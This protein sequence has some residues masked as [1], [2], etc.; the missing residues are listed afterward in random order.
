MS[1]IF[2]IGDTHFGHKNIIKFQDTR[3]FD[4]IEEHDWELVRRWNS[5]VGKRDVVYHLGDVV[6]GKGN[7]WKLAHLQGI[8]K[9]VLGNHDQYDLKEYMKYFTKVRGVMFYGRNDFVLTH[10]PVH[11]QQFSRWKKNIHGHLH[12][13]RLEDE[14]YVN[15]CCDFTNL[16]PVPLEEIQ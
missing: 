12:H 4:N 7:M 10:I 5:V 16:T 15:V 11:P 3:P 1:N 2:F 14:R 8:K 6:F 13:M 9:L